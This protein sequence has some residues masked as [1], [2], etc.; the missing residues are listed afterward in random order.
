VRQQYSE[1]LGADQK[2]NV[3]LDLPCGVCVHCVGLRTTV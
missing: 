3:N 2:Y 1:M